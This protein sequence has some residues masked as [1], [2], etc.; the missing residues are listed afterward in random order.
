MTNMSTLQTLTAVIC[1]LQSLFK[2]FFLILRVRVKIIQIKTT[3]LLANT[4]NDQIFFY[5]FIVNYTAN[6]SFS[7]KSI[8][9]LHAV[10]NVLSQFSKCLN[11]KW[12]M[13]IFHT[14]IHSKASVNNNKFHKNHANNRKPETWQRFLYTKR[15]KDDKDL[16][17][18][19][20]S[21]LNSNYNTWK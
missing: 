18:H 2:R 1:R 4:K 11:N 16:H 3:L 10:I 17:F 9:P 14:H 19:P 21:W 12:S 13:E 5:P 20:F 6:P 8:P 15:Q 7:F